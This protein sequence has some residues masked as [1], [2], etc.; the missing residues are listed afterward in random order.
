MAHTDT[1]TASLILTLEPVLA[2]VWVFFTLGET[3]S[4][5]AILGLMMVVLGSSAQALITKREEERSAAGE[6]QSLFQ[7]H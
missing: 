1:L 2:P 7:R 3:P 6:G 4:P 5:P